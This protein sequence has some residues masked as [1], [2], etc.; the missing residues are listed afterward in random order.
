VTNSPR[1]VFD[2]NVLVSAL[3]LPHSIPRQAVDWAV[4]HGV[5]LASAE[6][7]DELNEVL[8]RPKFDR[9]VREEERLRFLASFI[10]EATLVEVG[11]KI[12][13]CRDSSDDKFL[14][15]AVS[16]KADTLIS[17]DGDLLTLHPFR[18]IPILTPE[19]FLKQLLE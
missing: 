5:I 14:E 3:L 7:I 9:Y 1:C 6:T 4:E 11:V 10:H 8:R 18:S 15:L 13:A 16:G 17:G 19:D 12:V 2:T